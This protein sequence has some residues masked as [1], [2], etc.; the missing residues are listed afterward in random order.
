M[1]A[2]CVLLF[3]L[4]LVTDR[5]MQPVIV[6]PVKPFQDFSFELACGFPRAEAFDDF[7]LGQSDDGFGQGVFVAVSNA[8][9]RHVDSGFGERLGVSNGQ[10]LHAAVR[11]VGQRA[12]AGRRMQMA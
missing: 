6:V 5:P 11:V 8:S 2:E 4:V 1:L 7:R 9:D 12:N 10:I 3:A